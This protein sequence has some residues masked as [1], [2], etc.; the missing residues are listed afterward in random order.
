[1]V[2]PS[3]G[4]FQTLADNSPVG[5]FQTDAEGLYLYVNRRWCEIAGLKP[6][7]AYGAGWANALHPRRP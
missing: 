2:N 1:M 5:I 6:E 7:Q 4:L 3:Q